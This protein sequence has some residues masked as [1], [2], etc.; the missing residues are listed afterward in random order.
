MKGI[1]KMIV[2]GLVAVSATGFAEEGSETNTVWKKSITA[3]F[4]YKDGNSDKTVYTA[5]IKVDRSTEKS[6]WINSLYG[7]SG[8]TDGDRTD[9][10]L[11]L[12][13][14]YRYKFGEKSWYTGLFTE[15]YHDDVRSIKYRITIGPNIGYY[16][17]Y[18]ENMKFDTSFGLNG[19]S[20]KNDDETTQ[21]GEYRA[22]AN[23]LWDFTE[24]ASYYCNLSCTM[25]MDKT[26]NSRG[27]LI[28][29]LRTKINNQ[30]SMTVEL[31]DDYDNNPT[32]SD[33]ENNDVTVL[34]GLTY[35]F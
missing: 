30:L 28:T 22:A 32:G 18:E 35:D 29:G 6:E 12:Q 7:I 34:G 15:G 20:E 3:G 1:K 23:F 25:Q 4:S 26:E 9:A 2:A 14:E 8:K 11:R 24:T 10:E 31:R 19:V 13:S 21:Y 17:V 27:L 5:N 33:V 16:W